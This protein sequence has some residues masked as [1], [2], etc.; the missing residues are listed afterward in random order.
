MLQG[1]FALAAPPEKKLL[2]KAGF[3]HL[4]NVALCNCLFEAPTMAL[5]GGGFQKGVFTTLIL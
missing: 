5:Q 4:Y 1:F 3:T 2:E